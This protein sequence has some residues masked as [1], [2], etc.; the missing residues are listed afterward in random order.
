[1]VCKECYSDNPRITPLLKPEHCLKNHTQYI[2]STCG[3]CIC[4]DRDE[5]RNV[6]RWNFPFK[7]LEIAKLY[8][9]TAEVICQDVCG[10]YEV[11]GKNNRIFY[12]IFHT[13]EDFQSYL[14]KNKDK[15][16]KDKNPIYISRQYIE[17]TNAQIRKL[18]NEEV[19]NYISE[20]NQFAK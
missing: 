6:Y 16:C 5:K 11:I 10:I 14:L 15:E 3:R 12:K 7:T 19:K 2:C 13:K 20:H 8:L 18:N 1:M 17:S 4:I 9:R